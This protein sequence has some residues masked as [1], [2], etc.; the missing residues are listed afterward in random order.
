MRITHRIKE[1]GDKHMEVRS[2]KNVNENKDTSH[3]EKLAPF[4][5]EDGDGNRRMGFKDA[6]QKETIPAIYYVRVKLPDGSEIFNHDGE[7]N[8]GLAVVMNREGKFG[9]ID[10]DGRV[11]IPLQYDTISNVTVKDILFFRKGSICGFMRMNELV[12]AEYPDCTFFQ[13][14]H[15]HV[16]RI[17]YNG[18]NDRVE[19]NLDVF[20]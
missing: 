14:T 7:F 13:Q 15:D 5:F 1:N 9:L 12:I 8:N 17:E 2:V 11:V 4:A 6:N 18:G 10:T 19:L 20:I 16:Y 3:F